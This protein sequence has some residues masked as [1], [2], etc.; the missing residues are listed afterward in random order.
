MKKNHIKICF[1]FLL[2]KITFIS[3][4]DGQQNITD[5]IFKDIHKQRTVYTGNDSIN[6]YEFEIF[7]LL[8]FDG[9]SM[10]MDEYLDF[11]DEKSKMEF[12]FSSN[13]NKYTSEDYYDDKSRLKG[14]KVT[15]KFEADN[16]VLVR[17]IIQGETYKVI[18]N[19]LN[20]NTVARTNIITE[21]NAGYVIVD[22][23]PTN[24]KFMRQIPFTD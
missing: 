18:F 23:I 6:L 20:D 22:I 8:K 14:K 12:S 24:E 11:K 5:N 19:Y 21:L 17:E 3:C 13:M 1:I 10:G 9:I 2:V 15:L 4:V 16:K 7:S